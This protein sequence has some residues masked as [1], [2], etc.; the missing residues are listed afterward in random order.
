MKKNTILLLIIISTFK[1]G[2]CMIFQQKT[3]TIVC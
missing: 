1:V 2:L 3:P